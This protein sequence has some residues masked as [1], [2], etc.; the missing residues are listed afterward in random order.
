M[1]Q[2]EEEEHEEEEEEHEEEE[3]E[4]HEE[5]QERWKDCYPT[6]SRKEG[7]RSLQSIPTR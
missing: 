4:E 3:E 5:E 1:Y 2:L 6:K 7:N